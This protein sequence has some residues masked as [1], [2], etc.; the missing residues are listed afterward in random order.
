MV[1]KQKTFEIREKLPT[2]RICEQSWHEEVEL[3]PLERCPK[4]GSES[5]HKLVVIRDKKRDEK[6]TN[7]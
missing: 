2:K 3:E 7:T 1:E 6:K 4:C 5:F